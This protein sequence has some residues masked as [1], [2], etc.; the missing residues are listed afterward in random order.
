M[1]TASGIVRTKTQEAC[2]SF[3]VADFFDAEHAKRVGQFLADC[4]EAER[5]GGNFFDQMAQISAERKKQ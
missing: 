4:D 5:R 3:E 2:M 1:K